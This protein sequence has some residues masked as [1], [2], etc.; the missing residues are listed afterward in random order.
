[1]L[2]K[3][4]IYTCYVFFQTSVI[5]AFK[6]GKFI[7]NNSKKIFV[8]GAIRFRISKKFLKH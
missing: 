7:D 5:S 2:Y 4:V 1:M 8:G 3:Q 6:E